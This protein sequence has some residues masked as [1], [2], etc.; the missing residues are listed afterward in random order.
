MVRN[1]EG[2]IGMEEEGT[3]KAGMTTVKMTV[4]N[5][6]GRGMTAEATGALLRCDRSR[7]E[8]QGGR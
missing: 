4:K 3:K 7:L 2:E 1:L 8:A 5:L 6:D